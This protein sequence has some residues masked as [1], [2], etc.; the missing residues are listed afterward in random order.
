LVLSLKESTN[1]RHIGVARDYYGEKTR[2]WLLRLQK[3]KVVLRL[4]QELFVAPN[5]FMRFRNRTNCRNFEA[6]PSRNWQQVAVGRSQERRDG[7]VCGR[8]I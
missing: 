4:G 5:Y 8:E 3:Q 1:E 6:T 7:R 2:D